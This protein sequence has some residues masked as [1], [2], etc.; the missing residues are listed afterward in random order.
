MNF[1]SFRP[2]YQKAKELYSNSDRVTVYCYL[3]TP[4]IKMQEAA[5]TGISIPLS[6]WDQKSET[7]NFEKR[8]KEFQKKSIKFDEIKKHFKNLDLLDKINPTEIRDKKIWL[9]H[10]ILKAINPAEA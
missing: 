3:K 6:Y 9:E 8:S 5:S 7:I 10:N 4:T 2:N 1:I